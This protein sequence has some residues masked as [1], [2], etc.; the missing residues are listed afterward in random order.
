MV[1]SAGVLRAHGGGLVT[2][3]WG[4][5]TN[6]S[7]QDRPVSPRALGH[8]KSGRW[9]NCIRCYRLP[10]KSSTWISSRDNQRDAS[11]FSRTERS[12]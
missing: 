6:K 1:G 8:G 3:A 7:S 11:P 2:L 9:Y 4:T 12:S 5:G 10:A